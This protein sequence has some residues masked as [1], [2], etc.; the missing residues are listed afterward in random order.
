MKVALIA[1]SFLPDPGRLERRVDRLARGL[2]ARG[3]QVEVLTQGSHRRLELYEGVIVRRFPNG[4]GPLRFGVAPK[5]WDQL[6][7]ASG[8]F[9]IVDVHTRQPS[10][11]LAV[12]RGPIRRLV[13]TPGV[14]IEVLLGR[15]YTRATRALL[16][17]ASQVVCRSEMERDL[18]CTSVP[19]VAPRTRVVPDGVDVVA[20]CAAEPFAVAGIVVLS[21]DRLDRTT[22]VGRAIAAMPSLDPEF[23]LVVV[24]D[25]PARPRLSAFAADLRISSRVDF[26]GAVSDAVLGRWL[27]T[28]RVVVTLPAERSSGAL[29]TEARA[30][31]VTV[32][33][34][35]LPIH[36]QAAERPGRGHV[37]LVPPRASPLDVADAIEEAARLPIISELDLPASSAPSWESVV[38]STWN[39]YQGLIA[40]AVESEADHA[41]SDV[42]DL[43]TR[44]QV[45]GESLP[46]EVMSATAQA[47]ADAAS[48]GWWQTR[49]RSERGMNGARPWP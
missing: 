1:S 9:D 20:L 35:D 42:V 37:I 16:A 33:G 19:Q 27:R 21:V 30:V 40:G 6:R 41:A 46:D 14:S 43:T 47:G 39:L 5:L 7:L 34:S 12:A 31:G 48:V 3:A 38:D 26:V 10:L 44:L 15:P 32:V 4:V 45:G 18:L 22:G 11:A 8:A 23:R 24:G 13:L 29:L 25:G 17:S 36:R 2:A 28:A 49:L